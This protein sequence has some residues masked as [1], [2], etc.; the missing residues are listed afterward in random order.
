MAVNRYGLHTASFIYAGPTTLSLLQ[1]GAATIDT[2][3]DVND[4]IPGG[5]VDRGATILGSASPSVTITTQDLTTV[6]GAVSPSVGLKCTS[7]CTFRAQQRA[8]G[9]VFT[10]GSNN[11]TYTATQG[12]LYPT[13]LSASGNAPA[14]LDL[15]FVPT[16]DGTNDPL[17]DASGAAISTTPT[18]T[19]AFYLGAFYYGA[20][21]LEGVTSMSI[22]FGIQYSRTFADGNVYAKTGMIMRRT[23]TI[24]VTCLKL[25]SVIAALTSMFH[26]TIDDVACYFQKGTSGG[27]RVP[28]ITASHCKISSS[29]NGAA[30]DS[31]SVSGEDDYTVTFTIRPVN[32][33]AASVTSAIP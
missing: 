4:F 20:T 2:G 10:G 9:G 16:W 33:L 8:D 3:R 6:F 26:T 1:V 30:P 23:P 11:V 14:T 29:A 25:E 27:A 5:N 32:A 18:F 31:I 19:S 17:V 24:T 22:D 7:T 21:Q 12:F 13:R 28:L 15:M